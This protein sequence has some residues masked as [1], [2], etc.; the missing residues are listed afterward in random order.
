[1]ATTVPS[2]PKTQREPEKEISEQD[3]LRAAI[4][5]A[6]PGSTGQLV[7]HQISDHTY[8][9]NWH[10]KSGGKYITASK[11]LKVNT[12]PDGIQI[13]DLSRGNKTRNPT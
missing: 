1:M 4:A 13:E 10:D 3:L 9:V 5:R 8:R 11:F 7:I 6:Y 2:A 12:T